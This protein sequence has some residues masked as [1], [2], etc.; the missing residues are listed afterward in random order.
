MSKQFGTLP[1]GTAI[2]SRSLIKSD[3]TA[4]FADTQ[5]PSVILRGRRANNNFGFASIGLDVPPYAIN[6][7]D[8]LRLVMVF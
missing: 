6:S 5:K 1:D 7:H 4:V 3:G 8:H 2:G